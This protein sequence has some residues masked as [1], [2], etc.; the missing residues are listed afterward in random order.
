ME[1]YEVFF[2]LKTVVKH[3]TF[4]ITNGMSQETFMTLA[5]IIKM[6]SD[7]LLLH[8]PSDGNQHLQSAISSANKISSAISSGN[9][10][11][12]CTIFDLIL[13]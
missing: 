7:T 3:L 13:I 6:Y 4:V 8:L 1:K 11:D 12:S 10:K 2:L 9:K 5:N